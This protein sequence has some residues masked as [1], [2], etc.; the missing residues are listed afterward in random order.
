[1]KTRPQTPPAPP[2]GDQS[3]P[4][5]RELLKRVGAAAGVLA[6]GAVAGR[7]LWDRGGFGV[8]VAEGAR[9]VRDFRVASSRSNAELP[10][11]AIARSPKR[12]GPED[13]SPHLG[14]EALVAKAMEAMG[15]MSRFISRGDV[16]VIKPNIG[17]DRMPVHAANTNP[18]VGAAVVKQASTRAPSAWSWP[19]APATI[20]TAASALGDLAEG[21]RR[22][23]RG[24]APGRAP[25]PHHAPQG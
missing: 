8:G 11:L 14:P 9:Q 3:Q 23:S 19:T 10:E 18:D 4:T 7:V 6:G 5:R 25:L 1:M 24:R 13:D 22:R 16:V 17:W 20:R 2:V 21:L 12:E 15:G